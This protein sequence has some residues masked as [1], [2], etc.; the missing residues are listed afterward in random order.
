M[1]D[2]QL[3]V[4]FLSE[5]QVFYILIFSVIYI[6]QLVMTIQNILVFT[7]YKY[8][9]QLILNSFYISF[10]VYGL[11]LLN[12]SLFVILQSQIYMVS[13]GTVFLIIAIYLSLMIIPYFHL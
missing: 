10:L 3:Y 5:Q 6:L 4:K 12:Q 13:V 1:E 8:R 11:M 9:K 2:M 7:C